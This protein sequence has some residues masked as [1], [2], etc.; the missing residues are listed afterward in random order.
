R[1]VLV[2]HPQHF[3]AQHR[4]QRQ[5]DE[6]GNHDGPGDRDAELAQQP[7]RG[8]AEES[9]GVKTAT[10]AI[11][12]AITAKPISPVPR[13]AACSG[14]SPSSSWCRYAFSSTMMASSTTMPIAMVS[15]SR[16]KLL[17]E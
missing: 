5:R 16:V 2:R 1:P 7:S 11:V 10:R 8:A 12:V 4:R 6:S 3:R 13:I 14:A 15:A 17:I 9:G